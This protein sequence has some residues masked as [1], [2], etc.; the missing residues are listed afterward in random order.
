MSEGADVD[1]F[2]ARTTPECRYGYV[3]ILSLGECAS[4]DGEAVIDEGLFAWKRAVTALVEGTKT[5]DEIV[6]AQMRD[7]RD[8]FEVVTKRK[9]PSRPGGVGNDVQSVGCSAR[10]HTL[11]ERV[12][13]REA[14]N[15]PEGGHET[16]PSS[17]DVKHH[18][19]VPWQSGLDKDGYLHSRSP[20]RPKPIKESLELDERAKLRVK[21]YEEDDLGRYKHIVTHEFVGDNKRHAAALCQTHMADDALLS[22]TGLEGAGNLETPEGPVKILA[23]KE[24]VGDDS[25]TTMDGESEDAGPVVRV[26]NDCRTNYPPS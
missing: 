15:E 6:S 4:D 23:K 24:W 10:I 5:V 2:I 3:N 26:R 20:L 19:K 22:T 25:P 8:V 7:F 12:A 13:L 9:F 14:A 21:H 11:D 18:K 16:K 17:A 1:T